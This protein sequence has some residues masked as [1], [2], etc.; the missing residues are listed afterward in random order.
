VPHVLRCE[1]ILDYD[2]ILAGRID[3]A[4]PL[5]AGSLE[6]I[7]IRAGAVHAVELLVAAIRGQ[8]GALA[9]YELDNLLWHRGQRPEIKARPRHRTRSVFY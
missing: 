6:E 4:Q 5:A 1:G 8:G 9:A 7:E 3:A 2:P